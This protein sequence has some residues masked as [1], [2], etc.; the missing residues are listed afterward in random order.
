MT[1]FSKLVKLEALKLEASWCGSELQLVKTQ[2][3][4]KALS[5]TFQEIVARVLTLADE[6]DPQYEIIESTK[7][8]RAVEADRYPYRPVPPPGDGWQVW[9]EHQVGGAMEDATTCYIWRRPK[10]VDKQESVE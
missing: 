8:E 6:P 1:D 2:A 10:P 3:E 9:H 4:S 7:T 5:D